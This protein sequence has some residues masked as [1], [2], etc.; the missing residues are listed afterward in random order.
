MLPLALADNTKMSTSLVLSSSCLKE[1]P[2]EST[3]QNQHGSGEGPLMRRLSAIWGPLRAFMLVWGRV[4][5]KLRLEMAPQTPRKL[6]S[7][8][9]LSDPVQQQVSSCVLQAAGDYRWWGGACPTEK[10]GI[11][12]CAASLAAVTRRLAPS[13]WSKGGACEV[14]V[15]PEHACGKVVGGRRNQRASVPFH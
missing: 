7:S 5:R 8:G 3:S 11:A 2:A 6:V 10:P 12:N 13:M 15:T 9:S 4:I 1:R 14:T